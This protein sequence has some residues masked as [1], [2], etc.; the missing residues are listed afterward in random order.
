MTETKRC[1]RCRKDLP[2]DE[3]NKS[4]R[5]R[6]GYQ[7]RCRP[8]A[9]AAAR[10]AASGRSSSDSASASDWSVVERDGLCAL[11]G[12]GI[13]DQVLV[14]WDVEAKAWVCTEHG[15]HRQARSKAIVTCVH[16]VAATREL[17][18]HLAVAIAAVIASPTLDRSNIGPVVTME[19]EKPVVATGVAPG[20]EARVQ[21]AAEHD[22]AF[23]GVASEVVVRNIGDLT[24]EEREERRA[25]AEER[26]R[27]SKPRIPF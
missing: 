5:S 13:D 25:R 7:L 10:E 2:V 11:V 21:K 14:D 3:F 8:C 22:A 26:R 1:A 12:N 23:A 16:T 20:A 27:K 24:E 15:L 18:R 4:S 19:P 17:P 6:D 9:S